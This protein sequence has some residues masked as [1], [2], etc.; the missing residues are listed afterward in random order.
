MVP[1][2]SLLDIILPAELWLWVRLTL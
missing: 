1:L 2:E